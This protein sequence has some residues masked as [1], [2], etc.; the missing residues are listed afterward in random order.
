MKYRRFIFSGR[1]L[2]NN[3]YQ[4]DGGLYII[5][6]TSPPVIYS[7]NIHSDPLFVDE[8]SGDY[9]LNSSSLCRDAGDNTWVDQIMIDFEGDDRIL[10]TTVDIGADEYFSNVIIGDINGDEAVNLTD[11]ITVLTILSGGQ[12]TASI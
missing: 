5:E 6:A 3:D 4:T 11:A 12:P 10:Y 1:T 7:A 2:Y 8:Q 9:H